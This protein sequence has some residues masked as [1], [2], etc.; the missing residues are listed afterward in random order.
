MKKQDN[1][2]RARRARLQQRLR[3]QRI[4]NREMVKQWGP[5]GPWADRDRVLWFDLVL[6]QRG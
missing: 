5:F 3:T 2:R 1:E 4:S 6:Y